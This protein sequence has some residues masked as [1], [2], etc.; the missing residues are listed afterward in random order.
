ML[1]GWLYR[2]RLRRA[3]KQ[4]ARRLGPQLQRAYG[5]SEHYSAGQIRASVAKLGLKPKFIALGYAAYL[6]EQ[7]YRT[8][9]GSAPIT[10][11]YAVALDLFERYRPQSLFSAT[12][13][14]ETTIKIVG[15][16]Y[17]DH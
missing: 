8:E 11:P 4:Y 9:A 17:S 13:N 15:V 10:I 3:A 14:P 12:A 5:A 2:W 1:N 16:G 7:E 6:P